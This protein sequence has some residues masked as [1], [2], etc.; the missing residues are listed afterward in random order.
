MVP[1]P[2]LMLEEVLKKPEIPDVLNKQ[3]L[4][5]LARATGL[6]TQ[7]ALIDALQFLYETGSIFFSKKCFDKDFIA[8]SS[9]WITKALAC[10]VTEH[11]TDSLATG[12]FK[13]ADISTIWKEYHKK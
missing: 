2:Y 6:T 4:F 8:L 11:A 1:I 10:I 7:Q 3:G 9:Q 12:F 5:N 13:R